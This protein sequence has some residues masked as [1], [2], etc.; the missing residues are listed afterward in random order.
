MRDLSRIEVLSL[1]I[2]FFILGKL[3]LGLIISMTSII[4]K[5]IMLKCSSIKAGLESLI[6]FQL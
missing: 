5:H 2:L 3:I 6:C 1:V 4:S